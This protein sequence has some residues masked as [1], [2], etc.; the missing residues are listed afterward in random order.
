MEG[1]FGSG[2]AVRV[3]NS[4]GAPTIGRSTNGPPPT[5][6]GK[7]KTLRDGEETFF[8]KP[9]AEERPSALR[10]IA[11]I[12]ML[13]CNFRYFSKGPQTDSNTLTKPS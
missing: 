8:K 7:L 2:F 1:V 6:Q 4:R 5:T 3:A 12:A 10:S 11:M 9:R 13:F